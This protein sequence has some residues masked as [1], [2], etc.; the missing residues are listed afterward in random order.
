MNLL[1]VDV[2]EGEQQVLL[3]VRFASIDRSQSN[4]LAANLFS[5]GGTNTIGRTS[6]GQFSA[7]QPSDRTPT[8]QSDG[9]FRL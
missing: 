8:K 9:A 5:M 1:Y 3:K 6:T 2:P 4:E 7:A